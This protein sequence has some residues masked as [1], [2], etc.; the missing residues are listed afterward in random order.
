MAVLLVGGALGCSRGDRDAGRDSTS[1]M[2]TSVAG[3]RI[4]APH[5]G[6]SC[7]DACSWPDPDPDSKSDSD[8]G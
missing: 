4:A 3:T 5:A 7:C 6:A 2:G 1:T 8:A